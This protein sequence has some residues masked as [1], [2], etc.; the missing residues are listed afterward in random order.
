MAE[1]LG[2]LILP[3]LAALC[4]VIGVVSYHQRKDGG[5]YITAA[6]LC[7]MG[8]A[9]AQ[10]INAFVTN[11]PGTGAHDTYYNAILNLINW[12]GNVIM[13]MFAVLNVIRGVLALGGFMER[14]NIGEDW[15]RYFIIAGASMMISGITRLLEHFV[16]SGASVTLQHS[17]AIPYV[18]GET[19]RCLCV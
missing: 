4:V 5:R 7:L 13:P 8:P 12:V 14:F 10:L 18:I 9:S 3:A 2:Y 19:I 17:Q 6:V 15:V 16:T 11:T 1:W